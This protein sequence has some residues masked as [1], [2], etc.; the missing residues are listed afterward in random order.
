MRILV[1]G[2]RK[3]RDQTRVNA[4]LDAVHAKHVITCIVHGDAEGADTLCDN[5]AFANE[6]PVVVYPCT[7]Q[8][9]RTMG[10]KAGIVRNVQM[11]TEG[12]PDAAVAFP[13]NRGTAHMISH[14][15]KK[16]TPLWIIK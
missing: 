13:G 5:W 4:I 10:K 8:M 9:W 15:Q 7:P 1:T 12:K 2:G 6:V 16:G 3:Y 14:C 11:H